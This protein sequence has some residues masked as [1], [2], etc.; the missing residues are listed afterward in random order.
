MEDGC[1]TAA[2]RFLATLPVEWRFFIK[3]R[4]FALMDQFSAQESVASPS[5]IERAIAVV[6]KKYPQLS[7]LAWQR[8]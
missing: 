4:I 3:H 6:T 1:R 2:E 8:G 7:D 5:Q